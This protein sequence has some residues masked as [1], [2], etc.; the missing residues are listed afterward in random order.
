MNFRYIEKHIK[1]CK[2][3]HISRETNC[4]LFTVLRAGVAH[5]VQELAAAVR[6]GIPGHQRY[7]SSQL[8]AGWSMA[9][10]VSCP[11]SIRTGRGEKLTIQLHRGARLRTRIHA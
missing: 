3:S 6:P 9:H 2:I 10:P 11:M 4:S 5:S 7:F 1:Q 8:H